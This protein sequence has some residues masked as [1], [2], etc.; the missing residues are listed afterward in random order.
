MLQDF[1]QVSCL[2]KEEFQFIVKYLMLSQ[3]NI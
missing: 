1:E 3:M 2:K